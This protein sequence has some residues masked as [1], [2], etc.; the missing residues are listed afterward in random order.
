MVVVF[1]DAPSKTVNDDATRANFIEYGRRLER[2]LNEVSSK[3][4]ALP[5]AAV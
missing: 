4:P 5:G 3:S 1:H 2:L